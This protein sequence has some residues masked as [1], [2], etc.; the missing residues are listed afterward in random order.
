M[1]IDPEILNILNRIQKRGKTIQYLWEENKKDLDR[2][3]EI[4]EG[5]K[6]KER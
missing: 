6:R 2:L 4:E 5:L 3:K 1:T